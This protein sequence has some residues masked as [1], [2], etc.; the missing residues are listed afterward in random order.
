M[1]CIFAENLKMPYLLLT[2]S[3]DRLQIVTI[4]E[5]TEDQVVI[6]FSIYCP[7]IVI[8]LL[9]KKKKSSSTI[10]IKYSLE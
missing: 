8:L 10:F 3:D 9:E 6:S 7:L 1:I 2:K 5:G 4:E